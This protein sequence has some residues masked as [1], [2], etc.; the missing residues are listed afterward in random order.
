MSVTQDIKSGLLLEFF[1]YLFGNDEGYVSIATTRPPAR[2]DTFNE[3]FFDWPK[4]R[5]E[6][7]EY[8]DKVRPSYNVYFGVNILSVPRRKKENT[9]PQNLVWADL[10]SCRPDQLDVPPQCV[11]ES[12][13]NH[14]QGIWRM[15]EKV[16]PRIAEN[17]SKRIA[18]QYAEL[19]AD[20]TGHD[21]TQ[22]LRVPTT[23]NFKYKMDD[24]PEITV[25]MM[26]TLLPIEVFEA[27]PQPTID[28]VDI[29]EIGI[30]ELGD[31]PTPEMIMHRYEEHLRPTAFARYYTNEPQ[32]D[33]SKHLWRLINLCFD[34]GMTATEAFVIAKTSKCNKYERDGRPESH[35]WRE[36]LKA[37]LQH[38]S[39]RTLLQD[40]RVL[41]MPALLTANEED[42]LESTIIDDYM[43][44]ATNATDAVSDYHEI[45]CCMVMSAMMATTLRLPSSHTK[46][47]PNLWALI[48][49]DS[50]LTRK[51]TAMNMAMD[52]IHEIDRDM[53]VSS[54]ASPEGLL[55]NLALRPKMVSIFYRDEVTGFFDAIAHKEYLRSMPEIMTQLY[56]VPKYLIRTLRKETFVVS[57]PIFIFFGGGIPDKMYSLLDENMFTSGFIPRF[58]GVHGTGSV[59]SIKATGPPMIQEIDK[60][61]RLLQTFQAYWQMYTDQLIEIDLGDGQR[62]KQVPE[63]EVKM[64]PDMWE[65][66]GEIEH[67]LLRAAEE[68]PQA[69]MALPT[70]SRMYFSMLKL[71]MLFAAAR[72]EPKDFTIQ[73]EPR[74]LHNAAFYIQKWGK[75]SVRLIE[76]SGTSGDETKLRAIYRQIER[77]PGILRGQVMQYHRIDAKRMTLIE[78][79]LVQRLMILVKEKGRAR[80]YWP[81][82]R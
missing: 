76:N 5:E 54:D 74:D 26:D 47:I 52:F 38:K 21:L 4:Q 12:S 68:S 8:I 16:D 9:I 80:Q 75:H 22:L 67:I 36:V 61:S 59:E 44:W 28:D 79:T 6:M 81:I 78:E 65:R 35:L 60:R 24:V 3:Q 63:I 43:D 69:N 32:T 10:D 15:D 23:Y 51:T 13:P 49:G 7:V 71:T 41:A 56:D 40:H 82:G 29:P 31:A 53:I 33:W 77:Q 73:A 62:M 30:P 72:Q 50:T 1:D 58:L 20:K 70:F 45:C 42:A 55:Q 46:F 14:Y 18:Y 19:G 64:T 27:L 66:A 57:E 2:R 25:W 48:L 39:I 17:Y 37:E 34:S 11:I